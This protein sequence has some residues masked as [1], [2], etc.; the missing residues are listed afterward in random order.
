LE[1]GSASEAEWEEEEEAGGDED[2]CTSIEQKSDPVA[3]QAKH[4]SETVSVVIPIRS[5]LRRQEEDVPKRSRSVQNRKGVVD[6]TV[7]TPVLIHDSPSASQPRRRSG[8]GVLTLPGPVCFEEEVHENILTEDSGVADPKS[9]I[10][11][12]QLSQHR[13]HI[14]PALLEPPDKKERIIEK[15]EDYANE[16]IYAEKHYQ[17]PRTR[18]S[19]RPLRRS[20]QRMSY[21]LVD[22]SASEDDLQDD[23]I[24][25]FEGSE[26]GVDVESD[27][28][29]F[30]EDEAF[31]SED[32]KS[33]SDDNFLHGGA[34][35]AE[36]SDVDEADTIASP[37]AKPRKKAKS[38]KPAKRNG[39][40][41]GIDLSLPPISNI[42]DLFEI[43]VDEALGLGLKEVLAGT[44]KSAMRLNVATIFS[45]TEA[46]LLAVQQISNGK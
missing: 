42:E 31:S 40:K 29:A 7:K 6:R 14:Q 30:S 27:E 11:S 5:S 17:D 24:S 19:S 44:H 25:V 45:G 41:C 8:R 43:F 32:Y 39:A 38:A 33:G 10:R 23:E 18:L 4:R 9:V 21:T 37:V 28:E 36:G 12:Y 13:S 1:H 35:P 20:S 22:G 3:P 26:H 16:Q 34:I 15:M 2:D 46:P